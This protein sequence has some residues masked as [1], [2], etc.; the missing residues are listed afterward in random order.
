M[1]FFFK[2]QLK[3]L[4]R[5]FRDEGLNPYFGIGIGLALFFAISFFLFQK[6]TYAN[7]IYAI[8]YF[9]LVNL[10]GSKTRNG[11]LRQLF[12]KK[13]Y[14]I[15]R[16]IENLVLVLPFLAFLLFNQ[17]FVL[18]SFV[19]LVGIGLSFL[20]N[21][22][23]FQ[24]VIPTPFSKKPF[25]FIAGF[26]TQVLTLLGSYVLAFI[27]IKVEN[28]NIGAFAL[29]L[30]FFIVISF[31]SKPE[32]KFFVWIYKEKPK[33]FIFTKSKT[34]FLHC[35]VLTLPLIA[36]VSFFNPSQ[37]HI[38]VIIEVLGILSV[39]VSLF[40]KYAFFPSELNITTALILGVSI[41]LP[42][43]LIFTIPL[44]YFKAKRNLTPLLP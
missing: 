12:T 38:L 21:K 22:N 43:L 19:F 14:K 25:E 17:E 26:R 3:R 24:P 1:K 9:S 32:P 33:E 5:H 30:L 13:D 7:Y 15:I 18:A 41:L 40:G 23:Y 36:I 27:S 31:Y 6:S 34:A 28:F 11:I 10:L 42:P 35:L 20:N 2:L 29:I 37:I 4:L 39:L 16:L 8:S 44:F